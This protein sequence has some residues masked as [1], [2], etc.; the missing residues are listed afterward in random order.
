MTYVAIAQAVVICVLVV[1]VFFRE[2][3]HDT[4]TAAREGRHMAERNAL[5]NRIAHPEI[6]QPTPQLE[7]DAP[8]RPPQPPRDWRELNKIGT[9]AQRA[10]E[11]KHG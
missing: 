5:L 11:V 4:A 10:P 1:V 6:I 7:A 8:P 9:V 2:R 3:D